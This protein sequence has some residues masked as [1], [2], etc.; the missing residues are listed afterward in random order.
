[1]F[2]KEAVL[3]ELE[4][5]AVRSSGSGG[6]HVNKVA[7]KV[8]LSFDIENSQFLSEVQKDLLKKQYKNR[9]SKEGLLSLSSDET[10]SQLRNKE[11]V[12][13]RFLELLEAGLRPQK[14]RKPTRIPAGVKKKRLESKKRQSEK[15]INRKPPKIN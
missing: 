14:K 2:D 9:I 12:I 5:K 3:S 8:E 13:N 11:K 4:F 15:K 10:R 1:M 7:T 6:Q